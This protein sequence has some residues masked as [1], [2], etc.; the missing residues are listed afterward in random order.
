M[1]LEMNY[2]SSFT[3]DKSILEILGEVIEFFECFVLSV[4]LEL[5]SCQPPI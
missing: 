2:P 5:V 3:R 1:P 4:L